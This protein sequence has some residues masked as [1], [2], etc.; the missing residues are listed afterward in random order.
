M[1]F[2]VQQNSTERAQKCL[3][4]WA[5]EALHQLHI[6]IACQSASHS[7][8]Y[9]AQRLIARALLRVAPDA[10]LESLAGK[11]YRK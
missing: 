11:R 10:P 5:K 9:R 8:W 7:R 2:G 1:D 4:F 6:I 3:F